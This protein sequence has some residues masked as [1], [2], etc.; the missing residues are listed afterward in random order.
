VTWG[1]SAGSGGSS[2]LVDHAAEDA[3]SS[4]WGVERD[5]GGGLVVGWAL[6]AGLVWSVVVEVSGVLVEDR[7]G[8]PFVVDQDPVGAS[9][10][11]LRTSLSA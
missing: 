8:V 9:D 4:D 10:R 1:S 11:T 2:V 5:D 3:V 7:R 6:L